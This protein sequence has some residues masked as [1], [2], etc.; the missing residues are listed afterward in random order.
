MTELIL[1]LKKQDSTTADTLEEINLYLH[2][3]ESLKIGCTF[4][5][6][7][8]AVPPSIPQ[9]IES[10]QNH[11]HT[12]SLCKCTLSSDVTRSLIHSLQSPHC[13]LY[14]LALYGCTIPITDHTQ[15]TIAIVSN[16]TITHLLFIDDMTPS[17]TAL[18]GGLKH[19]TTIEQ[20]AFEKY[21]G[22]FTEGQFKLLIDAVKNS[23]VKKFWLYNYHHYKTWFI[24]SRTNVD[25][26]WH[27]DLCDL[28]NNW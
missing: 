10:Q 12:L 28:Y 27:G 11:L 1:H 15:L 5:I 23:T 3:L 13:K 6:F 25:I 20:L 19:N 9:F 4:Y 14:K 18:A 2:L 21:G 8:I 26:N 7:P 24:N 22:Y 17:L 16:T